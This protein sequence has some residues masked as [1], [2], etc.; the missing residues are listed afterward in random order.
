MGCHDQVSQT[1]SSHSSGSWKSRIK[2]P[3]GLGPGEAFLLGLQMASPLCVCVGGVSLVSFP[4]LIRT[5]ANG[6]G[7]YPTTSFN[8][9]YL[10]RGP[11]PNMVTLRIELGLQYKFIGDTIQFVTG[12][13]KPSSPASFLILMMRKLRPREVCSR[14]RSWLVA[15]PELGQA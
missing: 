15:Q 10:L 11:S 3:A 14:S 12:P 9:N 2:V 1:F 8:F 13:K 4:L 7:P 5:P 6:L